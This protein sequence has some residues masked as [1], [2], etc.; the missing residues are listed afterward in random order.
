MSSK[1]WFKDGKLMFDSEGKLIF[2]EECPCESGPPTCASLPDTFVADNFEFITRSWSNASCS[3]TPG[4]ETWILSKAGIT[5]ERQPGEPC[6]WCGEIEL[7]ESN[8]FG[9]N[10]DDLGGTNTVCVEYD[11]ETGETTYTVTGFNLDFGIG[12]NTFLGTPPGQLSGDSGCYDEV[13]QGPPTE[14]TFSTMREIWS[15]EV[16]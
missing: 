10:W 14:I 12:S 2:C 8:D 13:N 6:K 15:L 9:D 1:L 4:Q 5:I 16:T 11:E 3:G 7:E